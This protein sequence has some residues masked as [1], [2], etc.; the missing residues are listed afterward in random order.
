LGF[1]ILG[2]VLIFTSS[3]ITNQLGYLLEFPLFNDVAKNNFLFIR[4]GDVFVLFGLF[5]LFQPLIKHRLWLQ[6]GSKTLS[7]YI[8]HYFILYG[9][10]SGLGLY[11]YF[12]QSLDWQMACIGAVLFVLSVSGLVLAYFNNEKQIKRAKHDFQLRLKQ[13]LS[14]PLHK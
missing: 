1:L 7:L 11:K 12:K 14:Q 8:V 6:I 10:L 5:M 9:S 13:L 3:W 2:F 4:L